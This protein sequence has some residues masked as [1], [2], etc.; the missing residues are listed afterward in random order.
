[1]LREY[2]QAA[3]I[4]LSLDRLDTYIEIRHLNLVSLAMPQ[5]DLLGDAH[6]ACTEALLDELQE[7]VAFDPREGRAERRANERHFRSRRNRGERRPI[8][9]TRNVVG[10]D[11][12]QDRERR[13]L[14]ETQEVQVE[15]ARVRTPW[16]RGLR[17]SSSIGSVEQR[18]QSRHDALHIVG[19]DTE[20]EG[21][22]LVGQPA[23]YSS[24]YF[25]LALGQRVGAVIH[26]PTPPCGALPPFGPSRDP[27]HHS[28]HRAC[29]LARLKVYL[30]PFDLQLTFAASQSPQVSGNVAS[31]FQVKNRNEVNSSVSQP[32]S[33][34]GALAA[35]TSPAAKED[36]MHLRRRTLETEFG[37]GIVLW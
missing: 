27:F 4:C 7:L 23:S 2:E 5:P 13:F 30:P 33:R 24:E 29:Q 34:W 9:E 1:M 8:R 16:E 36:G 10:T 18:E 3:D 26:M 19:A 11:G 37:F 6:I 21:D 35:D 14:E 25:A 28:H 12:R 20:L 32:L 17:E 31:G 22:L 15:A